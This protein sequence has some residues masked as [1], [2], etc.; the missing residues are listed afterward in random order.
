MNNQNID[1]SGIDD[2][3]T[4]ESFIHW[5]LNPNEEA[6]HYWKSWMASNP[7]RR[8]HVQQA[9]K[10]VRS[11]HYQNEYSM[12]TEIYNRTML[13]IIDYKNTRKKVK[14]LS[15]I[16]WTSTLRYAA[17]LILAGTIAFYFLS[18]STQSNEEYVS[19]DSVSKKTEH[20]LKRTISLIDGSR[21]KL[22]SGSELS[23]D[24]T[25]TDSIRLVVLK[26]E[27]FFEVERDVDRPFIIKSGEIETRVLGTSF[28]VRSYPGENSIAVSVLTG[29]VKVYDAKGE[30]VTLTPDYEA[31]Y[32]K[33]SKVMRI[34]SFDK[35]DV[36]GWRDGILT[37]REEDIE[38]VFLKME[39]WFGVEFLI[40]SEVILEGKYKG[41]FN[42]P[43]LK[44]VLDGVALA[45]G[46]KY[47]IEDEN[48]I[49]INM[50]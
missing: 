16:S 26:G 3:L 23:Y 8:L 4:N 5:A 18:P 10:L 14:D 17:S 34:K 22:N 20:G 6:D 32:D 40:D 36:L 24:K 9:L 28:N 43:S 50:K 13:K 1:I 39:R 41:T 35:L 29:K 7:Q 38:K 2:L 15:S 42:N 49:I 37:F 31:V 46:F 44:E 27:A 21:V 19:S 12:D 11:V 25:F 48:K 30:S 45:S 33:K 47:E